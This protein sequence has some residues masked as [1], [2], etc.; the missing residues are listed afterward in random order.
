VERRQRSDGQQ[1][2]RQPVLTAAWFMP[3]IR[4]APRYSGPRSLSTTT[5]N[6]IA[7]IPAGLVAQPSGLSVPRLS[8]GRNALNRIP[9]IQLGGRDRNELHPLNWMPWNNQAD[10]YQIRDD[11]SWTKGSHQI[12]AGASWALYKKIQDVFATPRAASTFNGTYTGSDMGDFPAGLCPEL[13]G[14]PVSRTPGHWDNQSVALYAQDNWKASQ[15][16]TVNLG[17]RW[18]SIPHTYEGSNRQSNFYPNLYNPANAAFFCL[19]QHQPRAAPAS[20]APA[21]IH[22]AQGYKF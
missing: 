1:H 11:L 19:T 15:R 8:T 3:S 2:F 7:I 6:R 21:R 12:K 17:L 14:R 13:P 9:S 22:S 4:P 5:A 10:D 16:L 20:R 18:D